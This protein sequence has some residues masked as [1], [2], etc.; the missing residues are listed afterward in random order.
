MTGFPSRLSEGQILRDNNVSHPLAG[1]LNAHNSREPGP[2]EAW[3]QQVFL[4]GISQQLVVALPAA[5][6]VCVSRKLDL[7]LSRHVSM[8]RAQLLPPL[9]SHMRDL[10]LGSLH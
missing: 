6:T 2:R 10:V 1:S 7:E 5:P 4:L 8:V 9:P 3:S